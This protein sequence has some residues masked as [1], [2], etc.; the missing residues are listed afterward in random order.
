MG[1]KRFEQIK[2]IIHCNDNDTALPKNHEDHD[3]CHK[4]RPIFDH[5]NKQFSSI[6]LERDLALDEQLCA[7]KAR[8]YL[9]QYL[10]LKP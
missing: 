1:Q 9:K 6:P 8:S 5:L 10:P 3:R 2:S 4:L 7:T